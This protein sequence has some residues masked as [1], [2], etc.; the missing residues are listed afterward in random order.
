[1]TSTRPRT[2]TDDACGS[3]SSEVL[4]GSNSIGVTILSLS[5]HF[6]AR[7]RIEPSALHLFG[8]SRSHA[9]AAMGQYPIGAREVT[10]VA[11]GVLL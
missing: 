11:V 3:D 5:C 8:G 10:G 7:L 4:F 1:M 2:V 9:V 6:T